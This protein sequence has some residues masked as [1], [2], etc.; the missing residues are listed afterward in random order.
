MKDLNQC[1]LLFRGHINWHDY[2]AGF[3]KLEAEASGATGSG[4]GSGGALA[5]PSLSGLQ[6]ALPPPLSPPPHPPRGVA[7][8]RVFYLTFLREPV[9]RAVSEYRHVTEGLV[10]QFG[11]HTFGAVTTHAKNTLKT[12]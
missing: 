2:A 5:P 10:A 9:G 12:R 3:Q 11:P 6:V 4:S 8:L 7:G 1:S